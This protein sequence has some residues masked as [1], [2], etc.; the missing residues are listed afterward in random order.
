M[1]ILYVEAVDSVVSTYTMRL[2]VTVKLETL[3]MP[4]KLHIVIK[5]LY[6]TVRSCFCNVINTL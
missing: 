3:N 1:Y 2:S 5:Y 6:C 4:M